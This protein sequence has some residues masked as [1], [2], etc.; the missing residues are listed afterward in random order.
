MPFHLRVL[1]RFQ[2]VVL[3]EFL[4]GTSAKV[5]GELFVWRTVSWNGKVLRAILANRS[6]LSECQTIG[7]QI[8][9]RWLRT[10]RQKKAIREFNSYYSWSK[11]KE[12]Q[13]DFGSVVDS[14][15]S[16]WNSF[17]RRCGWFMFITIVP[18]L[19]HIITCTFTNFQKLVKPSRW[20]P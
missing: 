14:E 4:S 13:L 19:N 1:F 20:S 5:N 15:H 2:C 17:Q 10:Y 12:D 9:R 6:V 8:T 7:P 11:R 16:A 3:S 18:S